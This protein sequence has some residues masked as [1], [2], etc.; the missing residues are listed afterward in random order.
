MAAPG[1]IFPQQFAMGVL[2][3]ATSLKR[4]N[5]ELAEMRSARAS[6]NFLDKERLNLAEQ[7]SDRNEAFRQAQADVAVKQAEAQIQL[8]TRRADQAETGLIQQSLGDLKK[9]GFGVFPAS[10]ADAI[11]KLGTAE[12]PIR[13]TRDN[14]GNVFAFRV[15]DKD[16]SDYDK[17]VAELSNIHSKIG[18]QDAQ[19]EAHTQRARY[20]KER[21]GKIGEVLPPG[22]S[23]KYGQQLATFTRTIEQNRISLERELTVALATG[24][25]DRATNIEKKLAAANNDPSV[26]L[27]GFADQYNDLLAVFGAALSNDRAAFGLTKDGAPD[28]REKPGAPVPEDPVA[29]RAS[30]DKLRS[31]GLG[32]LVDTTPL[33]L[34]KQLNPNNPGAVLP[35]NVTFSPNT[36][37]AASFHIDQSTGWI[38]PLNRNAGTLMSAA[39]TPGSPLQPLIQQELPFLLRSQFHPNWRDFIADAPGESRTRLFTAG[40]SPE[41]AAAVAGPAP[42]APAEIDSRIAEIDNRISAGDLTPDE[43]TELIAE[44]E[45]LL[46]Q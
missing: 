37:R 27:P 16:V 8:S 38:V 25:K 4:K 5:A 24:K 15:N 6:R 10:A 14:D 3:L 7:Q 40:P 19:A 42:L 1:E 45:A 39:Q 31:L 2:Q 29:I 9:N 30:T 13:V 20:W 44:L 21:T 43:Q 26:L 41:P 36:P 18:L 34:A 35:P 22:S 23:V 12:E 32:P 11:S 46:A 17:A 33:L 28:V